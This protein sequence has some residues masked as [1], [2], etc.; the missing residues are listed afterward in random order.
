MSAA[1]AH[2]K[3]KEALLS[4]GILPW[5]L[6]NP[7]TPGLNITERVSQYARQ[8][9]HVVLAIVLLSGQRNEKRLVLT[10]QINIAAIII[11]S[12]SLQPPYQRQLSPH[13]FP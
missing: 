10:T 11:Q 2:K 12:S 5:F 8:L 13:V 9:W 3:L 1:N 6:Q 7:P 4:C